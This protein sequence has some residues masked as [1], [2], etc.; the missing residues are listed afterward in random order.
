[1]T[2]D[3]NPFFK[4]KHKK[5][6][7]EYATYPSLRDKS[8]FISGGGSG[9]GA[10]IVEHFVA[11]GARVTFVD[12]EPKSSQDLVE[13]LRNKSLHLPHFIHCDIRNINKLQKAIA[14]AKE[15]NGPI[16]VLVNNAGRDDRNTLEDMTP[17][18]WDDLQHV[19]LRHAYFACQAVYSGMKSAG[20]GSIINFSSSSWYRRAKGMTAYAAAKAAIVGMTRTLARELGIDNIRVN[21]V[22]PSWTVTDRQLKLWLTPEINQKQLERQCLKV[23]IRPPDIAR[24]VLFLAA[25]DSCMC[26]GHTYMVD[27]G[28]I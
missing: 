27:A 8:V 7:N 1:L 25:S 18:K 12:Y 11:Q 24:M 16:T 26:T 17:E 4:W 6:L 15:R 22:V 23:N 5:Q 28:T 20:G 19:N 9:I 3:N 10:C 2:K 21:A 14:E 13:G